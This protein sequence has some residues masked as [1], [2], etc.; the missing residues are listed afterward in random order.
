MFY[1]YAVTMDLHLLVQHLEPVQDDWFSLGL[2]LS[3]ELDMIHEIEAESS[4]VKVCQEKLLKF[5]IIQNPS[6]SWE[7]IITALN[8]LGKTELEKNLREKFTTMKPEG[9][10]ACIHVHGTSNKS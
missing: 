5:W 9:Y 8:K 10:L 2:Y 7:D 3:V 6:G 1:L 4:D